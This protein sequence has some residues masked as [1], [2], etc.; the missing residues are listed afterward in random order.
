MSDEIM[1]RL[2]GF[3][4]RF[5]KH[6]HDSRIQ[7]LQPGEIGVSTLRCFNC[8]GLAEVHS[9]EQRSAW[10]LPDTTLD[11]KCMGGGDEGS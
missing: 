1:D 9:L 6:G 7:T 4:E 10:F 2:E 5:A 8:G 3:T 11:L